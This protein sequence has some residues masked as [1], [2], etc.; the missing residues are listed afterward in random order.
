MRVR[1]VHQR[2]LGENAPRLLHTDFI[3]PYQKWG[4]ANRLPCQDTSNCNF[5]LNTKTNNHTLN[6][7][8]YYQDKTMATPQAKYP[9]A[10]DNH[11]LL[12]RPNIL[13]LN[14]ERTIVSL[15]SLTLSQDEENSSLWAPRG[16]G[17]ANSARLLGFSYLCLL[18]T[19]LQDIPPHMASLHGFWEPNS[20]PTHKASTLLNSQSCLF[21]FF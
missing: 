21:S 13:Q 8:F 2:I 18:S 1:R 19:G 11:Q 9:V 10:K 3:Y 20:C 5:L 14:L 16:L 15:N 7:V 12:L 17:L 4:K 6:Q